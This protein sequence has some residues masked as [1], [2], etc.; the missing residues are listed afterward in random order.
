MLAMLSAWWTPLRCGDQVYVTGRT[1]HDGAPP[2]GG[3]VE[4]IESGVLSDRARARFAAMCNGLD[5]A[6]SA[7]VHDAARALAGEAKQL[8][9]APFLRWGRSMDGALWWDSGDEAG[10]SVR[11]T[12]GGWS[13]E[14]RPGVFF[15]RTSRAQACPLPVRGG[16]IDELW[17][18]VRISPEHRPLVLAWMLAQMMPD[19]SFACPILY[20]SGPQ[21]SAKSTTATLI[22]LACGD[23]PP[24]QAPK[25]PGRVKDFLVSI[26][27]G[28]IAILDNL[29]RL[30]PDQSDTLCMVV[31]GLTERNR[32]LHTDADVV[33]L[34]IR[35]PM[36]ATAIDIGIIRPDLAERMV[37]I[38]MPD[39]PSGA[40]RRDELDLMH[41]FTEARPRIF[42]ALLDLA[43]QVMAAPRPDAALPRLADFGLIAAKI[44]AITGSSALHT[45]ELLLAGLTAGEVLD[46]PFWSAMATS[47]T[48]NWTGTASELL[49]LC[50]PHGNHV[51]EHGRD[52]P[53]SAKSLTHRLERTAPSLRS[54][55]WTIERIDADPKWKLP[56]R[57]RMAPPSTPL[58]P[59]TVSST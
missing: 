22:G 43:V 27:G 2:E 32:K 34:T 58:T 17:R 47:V 41:D 29:S 49:K 45:L 46:D 44:D 53:S 38:R 35:R 30:T 42:G 26:A 16:T 21:G 37:A 52:W 6:S 5:V 23:E 1:T 15:R 11:V 50:D 13:I 36:I 48:D 4:R 18:F 20:L 54:L 9:T 51:R 55:G 40:A 24:R 31:T 10:T 57:W 25:D 8:A 12:A 39:P 28:W 14:Q 3:V 56:V 7:A 59:T 19:E 33:E